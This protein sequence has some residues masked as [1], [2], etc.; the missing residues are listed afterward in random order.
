MPHQFSQKASDYAINN[1]ISVIFHPQ[2]ST[3]NLLCNGKSSLVGATLFQECA[4]TFHFPERAP[5]IVRGR[6]QHP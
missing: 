3:I 4:L 1:F 6:K 5:V 2:H